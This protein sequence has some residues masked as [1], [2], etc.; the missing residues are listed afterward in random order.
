MYEKMKLKHG[1]DPTKCK[2]PD[3]QKPRN[4]Q[5]MFLFFNGLVTLILRMDLKW[6]PLE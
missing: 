6:R 3:R 4:D 1:E 5:L 2:L